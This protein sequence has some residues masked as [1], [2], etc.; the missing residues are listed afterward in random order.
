MHAAYSATCT[1]HL[2]GI[3]INILFDVMYLGFLAAVVLPKNEYL[4]VKLFV[5]SC[6]CHIICVQIETVTFN[7]S[8]VQLWLLVKYDKLL[9]PWNPSISP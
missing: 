5:R 8:E 6:G 2:I 4:E 1:R 9:I 7:F 3:I